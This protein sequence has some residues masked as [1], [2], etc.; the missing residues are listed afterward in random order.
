MSSP[1]SDQTAQDVTERVAAAVQRA[2]EQARRHYGIRLPAATI[3]YSLRGRCAGQ[4][5]VAAN[6]ETLIRLN[7]KLLHENL[8][9]FLAQTIPHEVAHLVVTWQTRNRRH[10]PRPHGPEWQAVMRDCFGLEPARCHD[11]ATTP[12]RVVPRDYLYRCACREHRL[13]RIMHNKILRRARVWCKSCKRPLT[14]LLKEES[15]R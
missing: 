8:A 2:E 13:T 14:F 11:Y 5:R 3:D 6:G 12:A 4:A 15:A 9:D 10:R 7:R 1:S